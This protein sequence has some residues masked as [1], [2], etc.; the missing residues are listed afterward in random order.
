[1][2]IKQQSSS[3]SFTEKVVTA[4]AK[5]HALSLINP[6][7]IFC[8]HLLL[9]FG[10]RFPKQ[11]PWLQLFTG[12]WK[13]GLCCSGVLV[14]FHKRQFYLCL[15]DAG[16]T[17][18]RFFFFW[19]SVQTLVAALYFGCRLKNR[20]FCSCRELLGKSEDIVIAAELFFQESRRSCF[21]F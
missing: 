18:G 6:R 14:G 2:I 5:G 10:M 13:S 15:T 21:I 11:Q 9:L 17:G 7:F 19:L 16:R 3:K 12:H 8:S 1:M 20:L 4:K